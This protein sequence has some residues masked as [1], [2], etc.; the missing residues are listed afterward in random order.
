M[1]PIAVQAFNPGPMTGAGNVTWLVPGRVP[2]LIDAGTGD[3]RHLEALETALAGTSLV[4]VLVTHAHSDHAAGAPAIAARMPHVSFAKLPWP[5][6]DARYAVPW[7]PLSDDEAV[8]AGDTT[9]RAIHTPGHA[10]DHLCFWHA[11]TRTLFCG[12]LAVKGTTVVIP[13]SAGGDLGAYLASLERVL[14]LAPSRLLPAH[15][16]IIDD[17]EQVIRQYIAHRHDRERQ[18]VDALTAGLETPDAIRARV[19]P[20][21]KDVLVPMARESIM[22]HLLKLEREGRVRRNISDAWSIV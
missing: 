12:D 9:L 19:Y 1:K 11:E 14:A 7:Q 3:P 5:E 4:R 16:P 10:P 6:R 8:E 21:L 13:A 22:A 2:V 15:G 17:P 18:I 20:G